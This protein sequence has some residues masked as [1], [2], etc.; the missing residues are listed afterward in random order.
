MLSFVN[1]VSDSA[2]F[3]NF[4]K[5]QFPQNLPLLKAS[6]MSLSFGSLIKCINILDKLIN[7]LFNTILYFKVASQHYYLVTSIFWVMVS[8]TED[9]HD[10]S[11][12]NWHCLYCRLWFLLN[13]QEWWEQT[14]GTQQ[15]NSGSCVRRRR[16][17]K[18]TTWRI[19]TW[20]NV[21]KVV[22]WWLVRN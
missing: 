15:K 21:F 5:I 22:V 7:F 6:T 12:K 2:L 9:P 11:L 20:V 17:S 3:S 10:F 19:W 1:L 16:K 4:K 14:K 8:Y 13:A 18:H